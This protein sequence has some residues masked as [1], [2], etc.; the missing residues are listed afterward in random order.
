MLGGMM[1]V[2]H[3]N[4]KQSSKNISPEDSSEDEANK[5]KVDGITPQK[6]KEDKGED[7]ISEESE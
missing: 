1:S 7:S 5:T 3:C 2:P 4:S 6:N